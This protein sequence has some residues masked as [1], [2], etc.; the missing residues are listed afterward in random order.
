MEVSLS[1]ATIKHLTEDKAVHLFLS[2]SL[3]LKRE[4]YTK[5]QACVECLTVTQ[6]FCAKWTFLSF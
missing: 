5:I 1:S 2:E 6:T 4:N 3:E